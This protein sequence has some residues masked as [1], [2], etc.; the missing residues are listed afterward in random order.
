[1]GSETFYDRKGI[2]IKIHGGPNVDGNILITLMD[3][4][5]LELGYDILLLN[6]EGTCG[7]GKD[8][9]ERLS[10]KISLLDVDSCKTIIDNTFKDD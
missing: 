7:Y 6:Y 10:G 1:M 5:L 3:K 2:L 9:T 4:L 8:N